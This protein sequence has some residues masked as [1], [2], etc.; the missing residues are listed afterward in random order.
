MPG[1]V[2]K[3]LYTTRAY[4]RASRL[5]PDQDTRENAAY[6]DG[7]KVGLCTAIICVITVLMIGVVALSLM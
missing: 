4:D 3:R 5:Q 1:L 6:W 2:Q 7:F